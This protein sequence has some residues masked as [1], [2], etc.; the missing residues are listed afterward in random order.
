MRGAFTVVTLVLMRIWGMGLALAVLLAA[1]GGEDR[2][3]VGAVCTPGTTEACACSDGRMGT[4]VCNDDGTL[5]VCGS[6]VVGDGGA[7]DAGAEPDAGPDAGAVEDDAGVGGDAGTP[8]DAGLPSCTGE[9]V[10][11]GSSTWCEHLPNVLADYDCE[12]VWEATGGSTSE[13]S[14]TPDSIQTLTFVL[15]Y[16]GL[17]PFADRIYACH[18]TPPD[19]GDRQTCEVPFRRPCDLAD[20]FDSHRGGVDY[21][22]LCAA[23]EE[24]GLATLYWINAPSSGCR[25]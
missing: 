24:R 22:P 13:W 21:V 18:G 9:G 17:S 2:A 12:L 14:G 8:G 20:R 10:V 5:P 16:E 11:R 15:N 6:C 7:V 25:D 3:A 1:C 23:A 4:R 19:S